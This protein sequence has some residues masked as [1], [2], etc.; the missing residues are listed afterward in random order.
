MVKPD[1]LRD[2]QNYKGY[3]FETLQAFRPRLYETFEQKN[4]QLDKPFLLTSACSDS[5]FDKFWLFL[6]FWHFLFIRL[7]SKEAIALK[8]G[9]KTSQSIKIK[10]RK[11]QGC[12]SYRNNLTNKKPKEEG[13]YLTPPH[14]NNNVT[15]LDSNPKPLSS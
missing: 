13:L 12:N 8:I 10:I 9:H 14:N 4:W 15:Q 2:L 11:N 1:L 5:L 7:G 6:L 3:W